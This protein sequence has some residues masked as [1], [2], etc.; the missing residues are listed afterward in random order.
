MTVPKNL[1]FWILTFSATLFFAA[2]AILLF[3]EWWTVGFLEQ[4][5]GYPWGH[6]NENPWF[7][8]NPNLYAKVVLTEAILLAVPTLLTFWFILKKNKFRIAISLLTSFV[9]LLFVFINGFIQT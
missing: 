3:S 6:I 7:Y 1:I 9:I 8:G 5:G 4:T 2:I